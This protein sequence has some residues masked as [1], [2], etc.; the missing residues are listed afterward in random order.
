MPG[1]N[2]HVFCASNKIYWD[3]RH[4]VPKDRALPLLRLSGIL[5][6]RRHCLSLVSES[7]LRIARHYIQHDISDVVNNVQLW[8]QSGAGSA[9]AEQKQAVRQTLDALEARLRRV[10]T[11][12]R[13]T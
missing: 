12:L 8:V 9:N 2:L 6:I 5:D 4:V 10:G 11:S 3:S 1:G 7:Q 13:P